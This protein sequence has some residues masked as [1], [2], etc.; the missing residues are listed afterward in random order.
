M[1]DCSLYVLNGEEGIF[2]TVIDVDNLIVIVDNVN[3]FIMYKK[4]LN[5][6]FDMKD[7]GELCYFLGIQVVRIDDGIWLV[8]QQ[9]A[10]DMLKKVGMTTCKPLDTPMDQNI[11]LYDDGDYLEDAYMYMKMVRGLFCL[12][13]LD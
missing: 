1:V 8:Q 5:K 9:Y 12:M 10:I 13:K 2:I 11:K 3:A 4:Q 6:E 7:L